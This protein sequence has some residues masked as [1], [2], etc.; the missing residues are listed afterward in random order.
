MLIPEVAIIEK[1]CVYFISRPSKDL[2]HSNPPSHSVGRSIGFPD[3]SS[4]PRT[5]FTILPSYYARFT[6]MIVHKFFNLANSD[7][8]QQNPCLYERLSEPISTFASKA[9]KVVFEKLMRSWRDVGRRVPGILHGT[10]YYC[11]RDRIWAVRQD[12]SSTVYCK[13]QQV[14]N[15]SNQLNSPLFSFCC[16]L[17]MD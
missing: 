2:R 7:R 5:T 3:L 4:N 12:S 9:T 6:I 15:A 13:K 8:L 17:Q 14:W 10:C 1:Q 11:A 16:R